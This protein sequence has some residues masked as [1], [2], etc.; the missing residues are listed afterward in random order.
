[1]NGKA[2]WLV[3]TGVLIVLAVVV[4]GPRLGPIG[5]G[6]FLALVVAVVA[7]LFVVRGDPDRL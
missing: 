2:P 3:A 6:T 1:M 7:T 5:V 4:M